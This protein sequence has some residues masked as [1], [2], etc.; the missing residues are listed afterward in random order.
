MDSIFLIFFK[1][2]YEEA[3]TGGVLL[4]KGVLKNITKF[5][6]KYLV[7]EYLVFNKALDLNSTTLLK[8]RL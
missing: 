3:A 5:R 6:G 1:V 4:K 8:E 2:L 7:S